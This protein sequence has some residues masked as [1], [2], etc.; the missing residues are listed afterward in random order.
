MLGIFRYHFRKV[1]I[2]DVTAFATGWTFHTFIILLGL[3]CIINTEVFDCEIFDI[4][5]NYIIVL[6]LEII[7]SA[8]FVEDLINLFLFHFH[9]FVKMI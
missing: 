3:E 2:A 5:V 7:S 6:V 8:N 4:G 1:N 9:L